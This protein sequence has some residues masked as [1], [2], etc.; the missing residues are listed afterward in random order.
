MAPNLW[1]NEDYYKNP[2][3]SYFRGILIFWKILERKTF[4]LKVKLQH[5][6]KNKVNGPIAKKSR[7]LWESIFVLFDGWSLII[8]EMVEKN[9]FYETKASILY[10]LIRR[11]RLGCPIMKKK[12]INTCIDAF[13]EWWNNIDSKKWWNKSLS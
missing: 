6:K 9:F 5:N 4:L 2:Y 10:I 12:K 1:E 3:F 7:L 11:M 8:R 13:Q